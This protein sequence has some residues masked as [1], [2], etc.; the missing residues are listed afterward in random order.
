MY[1]MSVLVSLEGCLSE[2]PQP[3]WSGET[4]GREGGREGVS[5]VTQPPWS[6]ER[7]LESGEGC[8]RSRSHRGQVGDV[9]SRG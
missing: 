3:P 4:S 2:V 9:W 5:G 1:V 6:G 7:C 8:P